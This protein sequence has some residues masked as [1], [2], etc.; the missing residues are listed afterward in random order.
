MYLNSGKVLLFR[1]Y[2]KKNDKRQIKNYKPVSLLTFIS[3]VLKKC[4]Y[5]PLYDHFQKYMKS[6]QH[7]C[8]KEEVGCN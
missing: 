7:G 4:M 2:P 3:K 8:V 1:P 5:E 6:S